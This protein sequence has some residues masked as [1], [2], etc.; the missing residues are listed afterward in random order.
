[1]RIIIIKKKMDSAHNAG[2]SVVAGRFIRTLKNEIY[3]YMT[4]ISKNVYF[5]KLDNIGD[6]Y[7]NT[8]H[9]LIKILILTLKLK[10]MIKI[11]SF[12]VGDHVRLSKNKN[13]F[14]KGCTPNWSEEVFMIKN[15]KNTVPLTY[16]IKDLTSEEIV[17]TFYEKELQKTNQTCFRTEKV[18]KKKCDKLYVKWEGYDDSVNSGWINKKDIV[19]LLYW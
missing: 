6:E 1:M 16:L 18:M 2:T 14:A 8:Y 19:I 12:E 15:I 3:K 11:L 5:D 7:N 9:S 4:L 10:V 13:I 17:G